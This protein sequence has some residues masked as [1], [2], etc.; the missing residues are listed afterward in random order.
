MDLLDT[1]EM[2]KRLKR[3]PETLIRWR[4]ERIGPPY[5]RL[6]GRVLYDTAKVSAWLDGETIPPARAA[7]PPR[8]GRPIKTF[9]HAHAGA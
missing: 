3:C 7:L 5:Q 1:V 6:N 2:A 8:R 9:P 4:R